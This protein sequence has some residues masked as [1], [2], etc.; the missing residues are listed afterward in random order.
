ME[1]TQENTRAVVVGV[2]GSPSSAA[3][4]RWALEFARL[5]GSPVEALAAWD[6]PPLSGWGLSIPG[7]EIEEAAR[8]ALADAVKKETDTTRPP[9][10]VRQRTEYGHPADVLLEASRRARLLVVGTRGLGG[11]AGTLLGSV[12]RHCV[13]HAHCPVVV[14]RGTPA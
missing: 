10:P 3:A 9:V 14:V 8:L 2:D 12:S 1:T 11:F 13:E 4:L 6:Y 7:P 5:S